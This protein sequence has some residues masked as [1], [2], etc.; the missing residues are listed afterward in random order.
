MLPVESCQSPTQQLCLLQETFDP[1][2]LFNLFLP[3]IIFHGAYTLNQVR[4]WSCHASTRNETLSK[5]PSLYIGTTLCCS[6][7]FVRES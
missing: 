1:E 4:L 2:V 3:P 6:V 7:L 5:D